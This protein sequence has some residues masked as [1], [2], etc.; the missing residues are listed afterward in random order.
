MTPT[1][2]YYEN[3]ANTTMKNLKKRHFE[4]HY[5]K[6]AKEAT[7]LAITLVSS[8]STVSFGGSMTLAESGMAD[9]L[10]ELDDITLLDRSK[11]NSPEEIAEI[12]HK[13]LNSDYYFMSSNAITSDGELVNVDGT[14][15][16]VAA[17]IY[18]PK[19]VIILAGMN[20]VAPS[21]E[22][23]VSRVR[24]V[25]SPINANRLNRQTPCAATGLCSDC[26]SPD[27]IC[28]HTVITRRSAPAD[29]IKVIL[30]GES[31]GY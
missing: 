30:I 14:G 1:Q 20:K 23:A 6:T 19:N 8:G 29:R 28:S 7:E 24:N 17:L 10:K 5:C 16:R 22:E 2:I 26:L 31:L 13:S 15:N 9:R 4:C 3:L 21:L 11:A 27:C 25:A 12:Y 18:G